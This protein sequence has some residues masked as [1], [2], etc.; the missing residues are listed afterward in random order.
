VRGDQFDAA[1]GEARIEPV[2]IVG[3]V[4]DQARRE[5]AEE[6]C[7]ECGIDEPRFMW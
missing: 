3:A 2:A 4:A 7:G 6:A 1:A 5:F